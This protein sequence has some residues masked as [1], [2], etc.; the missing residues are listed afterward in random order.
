MQRPIQLHCPVFRASATDPVRILAKNPALTL[1][2][3]CKQCTTC[4]TNVAFSRIYVTVP[5]PRRVLLYVSARMDSTFSYVVFEN[6]GCRGSLLSRALVTA[7]SQNKKRHSALEVANARITLLA[8]QAYTMWSGAFFFQ[9]SFCPPP[10]LIPR[11]RNLF[12][13]C[14]CM[15]VTHIDR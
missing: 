6:Q 9:I 15:I 3:S 12:P 4:A 5:S 2:I 8:T 1:Y 10:N 7:F 14:L 11:A 13:P